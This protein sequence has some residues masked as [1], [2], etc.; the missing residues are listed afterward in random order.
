MVAVS[1]T[2]HPELLWVLL[3]MVGRAGWFFGLVGMVLSTGVPAAGQAVTAS[4]PEAQPAA[5]ASEEL[6]GRAMVVLRENCYTCHSPEKKK[7]GL[8]LASRPA[9]LAGGDDGKVLVPGR[10]G[11][12]MLATALESQADPH[13][14]PKH[15]L[16]GAEV[17]TIR[18][19]IAAGAAWDEKILLSRSVA[20]IPTTRPVTLRAPPAG[21]RP[22]LAVCLSRDQKRLAVG[23]GDRIVVFDLTKKDRPVE[24][25]TFTPNEMVFSLAWSEDGSVLASGGFRQ[26]RLWDLKSAEPLRTLGGFAGRVT[27]VAFTPDGQRILGGGGEPAFPGIIRVWSVEDGK[28]LNDWV[29]HADAVFSMKMAADG[30]LYTAGA[31][32][33]VKA[34]DLGTG[35][36]LAK[37]EGHVAQ[38]MSVVLSPNGK[39]I[40]SAGADREI[41]IWDRKTHEQTTALLTSPAGITDL[42]WV[43]DKVL[44]SSGEDGVARFSSIDNK[45]SAVKT[46]AGAADVLSS[47]AVGRDGTIYGGDHDGLVYTWSSATTKLAEKLLAGE[48]VTGASAPATV[49]FVNDVMPILS[50][51]GCN[52][53]SCHAKPSGQSG[54]KLSV[55]AYDPKSDFRAIVKSA[56][57]RRVFAAAPEESLLLKKPT[58]SVEHGGGRRLDKDSDGYHLLVRWIEEGMPFARPGEAALVGIDVQPREGRYGRGVVQ[59]L[60]VKA[61]YSDGTSR[62]VTQLA[63]FI[64][65]DKEVAKVSEDGVART[66]SVTGETAI[67]ARYMGLVDVARITVPTDQL[68]PDSEYASLPVNNFIDRLSHERLKSL[69][70]LPSG[71]C[72]DGEFLRRASLDVVGT[73]PTPQQS[74]AFLESHD[75]EKR[76]KLI[77]QL[78]ADPRYGDCW[79]GKWADLLRPNPFRVGVKSVY[80]FDQWLRECF[81]QNKPYDQFAREIVLAEGSTHRDGPVVIYRDRREPADLTTLFSQVFLGVRLECAKCHHHPNEKWSQD[82][83]Y[84]L[85]AF[86]SELK[87]KGQGISAPISGEAEYVWFAPGGELTHPVSGEVMH[88]RALDGPAVKL[89]ESH[90]PREALAEWM[91]RPENP[92]FARAL[93]NRVWGELMG[94]GI[95]QPVDDLRISNPATDD[96]LLAALAN[97]FVAH[98]FDIK[99]LI[100]TILRSRTY[101]TSSLANESNLRD[102]KNFS[103]WYRHRPSAEAL[104]DAV[105]EVTGVSEPLPGLAPGSRAALV[106]NNRLESDFLDAFARPN[107]SADPPCERDRDGSIVQALHLMNSTRLTAKITDS[108]GRAALL[109]KGPKSP[110]EIVTELYLAVYCRYPTDEERTIAMGAFSASGATRQSATEDVMWALLNSAEFVFNH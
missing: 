75:P 35:K 16:S 6:T 44:V 41:K 91:T 109:S 74:R 22:V 110:A 95:V 45:D 18:E 64:S 38:V 61:R 3:N 103:R 20:A 101:Q 11:E 104:L 65:N 58:L 63:D 4:I 88:P 69:G 85:A 25:E 84:Q 92:F 9:A 71:T 55:F 106:W 48:K 37:F 33:F 5:R 57:G 12:S 26:I 72:S 89:D 30:T 86:F 87:R 66:G 70:I 54:F 43:N 97:D 62:D 102:T 73:L 8:T 67:V 21:Y 52:A 82:D 83:F 15:Q 56:G 28:P 39:L 13:M 78:L 59:P 51:A 80:I 17:A 99:H 19:W 40:A 31:D 53:G 46:F 50:R 32:K 94:R 79:S 36:E 7:G 100:R 76:G 1:S 90:D 93:V 96:A 108:S 60:H 34:W 29:A 27:A 98:G 77:D 10:P 47:I 68:L 107:S 23:R 42:A 105:T 24:F 81:R 2:P 49:S 14:P